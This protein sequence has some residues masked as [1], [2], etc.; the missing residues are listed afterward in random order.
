LLLRLSSVPRC[1][2]R[3]PPAGYSGERFC[4]KFHQFRTGVVP[5]FVSEYLLLVERFLLSRWRC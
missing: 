5:R 4:L 1:I 2:K 3:C